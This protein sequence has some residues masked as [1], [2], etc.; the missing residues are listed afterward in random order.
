MSII[1]SDSANIVYVSSTSN[2]KLESSGV[3]SSRS[4]AI[5]SGRRKKLALALVY[6]FPLYFQGVEIRACAIE[7]VVNSKVLIG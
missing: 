1:G 2:Q 4:G 5:K 7:R 3:S 6:D